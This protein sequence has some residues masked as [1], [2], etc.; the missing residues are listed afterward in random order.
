MR[1]NSFV[2]VCAVREG[3]LVLL[4]RLT[5]DP[6]SFLGRV[7]APR[8]RWEPVE[9]FVLTFGLYGACEV[10]T[11]HEVGIASQGH[12]A[13]DE[14]METKKRNPV[15]EFSSQLPLWAIYYCLFLCGF[16]GLENRLSVIPTSGGISREGDGC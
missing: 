8:L 10:G 2:A 12:D 5:H 13:S 14:V 11:R 15:L 7:D 1:I 3:L 6:S 4:T 9:A 16:W